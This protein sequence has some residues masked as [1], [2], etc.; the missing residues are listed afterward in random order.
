MTKDEA[1]SFLNRL[2]EGL[3]V[4]FGSN[5]EVLINDMNNK[6]NSIVSIYNGHVTKRSL[7]DSFT[8]LGENKDSEVKSGE[9]LINCKA[10]TSDGRLLKSSTFHLKGKNYHYALGINFDYTNL[11]LANSVLSDLIRVG[12]PL[13]EAISSTSSDNLLN[14]I[15]EE[16]L[17]VIGKPVALMNKE[18]R[19]KIVR[20]LDEK[21]A[22]VFQKGIQTIAEKLNISRY[23]IYNYLK[24]IRD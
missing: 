18:D 6:E 5:C 17:A 11:S 12:L 22:F 8:L 16:S 21:G 13:E 2:A 1:L 15:F 23:T 7:G 10:N 24:E 9:D 19:V 14:D 3:S 4:M 20:I